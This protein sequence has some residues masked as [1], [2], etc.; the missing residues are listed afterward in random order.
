MYVHAGHHFNQCSGLILQ[1]S[2][3]LYALVSWG[4][5]IFHGFWLLAIFAFLYSQTAMFCHYTR[6]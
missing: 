1:Q 3:T 4:V 6:A 5:R 2:H